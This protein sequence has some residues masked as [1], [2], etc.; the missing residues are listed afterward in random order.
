MKVTL[1]TALRYSGAVLCGLLATTGS[2]LA[3]PFGIPEPQSI[4]L[5]GLALGIAY[6]F[7]KK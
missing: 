7:K 2:A 1:S 6:A 3:N 5:V 4:V